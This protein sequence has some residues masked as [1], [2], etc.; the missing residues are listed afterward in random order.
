[1]LKFSNEKEIINSADIIIQ[2]G[3][4]EMKNSN[5]KENQTLIGV[6]ILIIIKKK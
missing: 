6:L 4:S 2:L 3:L 5:L 1:M